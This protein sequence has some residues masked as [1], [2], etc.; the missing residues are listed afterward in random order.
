MKEVIEF[1][2]PQAGPFPMRLEHLW[3]DLPEGEHIDKKDPI[4]DTGIKIYEVCGRQF[5]STVS[6]SHMLPILTT[7]YNNYGKRAQQA[8]SNEGI[9]WK[10]VSHALRAALE[11]KEILTDG[12]ITFP[13]K[14]AKMLKSIKQGKE[15]WNHI[16]SVLE[17]EI[18]QVKK[19]AE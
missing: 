17:Y 4:D 2:T 13:L 8:A 16:Q 6:V 1:L 12:T 14:H 15:D 9:D 5:H 7:I 3:D 10:A 18:D 11:V 19:L